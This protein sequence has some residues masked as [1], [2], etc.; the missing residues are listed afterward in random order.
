MGAEEG[1]IES[2]PGYVGSIAQAWV[3]VRGGL[4]IFS[5]YIRHSEGR[6]QMHV[7][8]PQGSIHVLVERP[9]RCVD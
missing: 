2:I 8:A 5:V 4:R 9:K 1:V 3:N 6:E 7:V